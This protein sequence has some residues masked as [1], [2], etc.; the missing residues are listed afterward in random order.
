MYELF[1]SQ[2]VGKFL[3]LPS[4]RHPGN[5]TKFLWSLQVNH[6]FLIVPKGAMAFCCCCCFRVILS[7]YFRELPLSSAEA[8]YF[9]VR[10]GNWGEV[11]SKRAEPGE[12]RNES[13]WFSPSPTEGAS[14]E[15]RGELLKIFNSHSLYREHCFSC[16]TVPSLPPLCGQ[17]VLF[18]MVFLVYFYD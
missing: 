4:R 15:E 12:N 13:A 8:S 3:H 14:V 17:R 18:L 16:Y 10:A 5:P 6:S 2:V 9:F 1:I 11:K 7:P